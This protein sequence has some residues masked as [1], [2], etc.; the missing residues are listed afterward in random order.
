MSTTTVVAIVIGAAIIALLAILILQRQRSDRLRQRFG[1]EYDRAVR[2][3]GS[4]TRAESDLHRR[5]ERVK[6]FNIR[7]LTAEDRDR[8]IARWTQVQARFVDDPAGAVADADHLIGEVMNLRG[9]PMA[10]FETAA[11]DI[12]VD[13]PQVVENYR[14]AHALA[15][16]QTTGQATTEDLR[17]AMVHYRSL[18]EDL[19][20][21][22]AMARAA[23]A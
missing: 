5:E 10:D 21:A 7:P 18:F 11:A 13:H 8:F 14:A 19:A 4:T 15:L 3:T 16:R 23:R 2:E 17:R 20:G 22:P 12:S 6:K 9:Y 1:P